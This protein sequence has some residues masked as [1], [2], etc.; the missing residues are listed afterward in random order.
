MDDASANVYPSQWSNVLPN[1]ITYEIA[2]AAVA[3]GIPTYT[4]GT[5][6]VSLTINYTLTCLNLTDPT[7]NYG[8][9]TI[10][11]SG[12]S[13][14]INDNT[15]VGNYDCTVTA[16]PADAPSITDA[17]FKFSLTANCSETFTAPIPSTSNKFHVIGFV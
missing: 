14:L 4:L 6:C 10:S 7:K 13:I 5:T 1:P 15:A 3:F 11:A 9:Q 17:S 16:S 2:T 12:G 8:P